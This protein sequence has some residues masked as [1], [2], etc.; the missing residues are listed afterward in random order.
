MTGGHKRAKPHPV[1]RFS[2]DASALLRHLN[3]RRVRLLTNNLDK[4]AALQVAGIT[5]EQVPL[6]DDQPSEYAF[7]Y[8]LAKEQHGHRFVSVTAPAPLR[9]AIKA[10][11]AV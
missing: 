3:L 9:P 6:L 4:I 11:D 8:L 1:P 10:V 7:D 5:V 2:A